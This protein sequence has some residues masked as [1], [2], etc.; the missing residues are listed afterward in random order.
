MTNEQM[1]Q[2]LKEEITPALGCTEPVAIAYA[3][4]RARA[5]LGS[6]PGRARINVSRNIL[7]NAM[8]VGIPGTD[9]V[10]LEMAAAL[11]IIGGD[12]DAIL[13]VLAS[14]TKEHICQAKEYARECVQVSLKDTPKKLYI[15][16]ILEAEEDH[17]IVVIED[18]H[19]ARCYRALLLKL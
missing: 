15:E 14:V 5:V 16:V 6:M 13:E 1:I 2:I 19:A 9:M 4:A 7:K 10:G 17:A 18:S 11:G 8:G 12:S 3:A